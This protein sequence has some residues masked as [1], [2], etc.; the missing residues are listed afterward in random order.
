M[1]LNG[2]GQS[3]E[4]IPHESESIA[5]LE[6]FS[7]PHAQSVVADRLLYCPLMIERL[8]YT[9]RGMWIK[10]GFLNSQKRNRVFLSVYMFSLKFW[11]T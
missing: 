7:A 2:Q 5:I 3:P 8:S 10:I 6:E 1:G 9:A 4:N 11:K